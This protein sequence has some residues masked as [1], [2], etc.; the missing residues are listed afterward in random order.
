MTV[1]G[2]ASRTCSMLFVLKEVCLRGVGKLCLNCSNTVAL[3]LGVVDICYNFVTDIHN[4]PNRHNLLTNRPQLFS[5]ARNMS[6]DGAINAIV[7][8][9]LGSFTSK[10][11]FVEGN[12]LQNCR[13]REWKGGG[14]VPVLAARRAYLQDKHQAPTQ[15]FH[16]LSLRNRGPFPQK[17]SRVKREWCG[18]RGC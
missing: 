1:L 17:P 13:D 9:A 12:S 14:L 18:C 16:P 11:R 8:I 10:G 2:L 6:I 3:L 7:I 4:A 15:P 5:Q